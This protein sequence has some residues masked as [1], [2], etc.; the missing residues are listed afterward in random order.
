VRAMLVVI[1]L[2]ASACVRDAGPQV[3]AIDLV[4]LADRADRRPAGARFEAAER[5]CASAPLAGLAAPVPSRITYLLN[6][7]RQARLVTTPLLDG[8]TGA[9][10]EFRI[11]ISDRRTYETLAIRIA[12]AAECGAGASPMVIDLSLYGGWQWSLF[13][14]PDERTWE[15]ILG[16]NAVAGEIRGAMWG[17]PRIETNSRDARAFLA[18]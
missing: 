18:R 11:G 12:A 5:S 17:M 13:Y 9:S 2:A 16:V 10:A 7:P 6:F 1:A 8:S 14:R 4:K 3:T 15:L